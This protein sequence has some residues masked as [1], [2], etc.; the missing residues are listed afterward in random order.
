VTFFGTAE[1]YG[2]FINEEQ[3]GEALVLFKGQV[4]IATKM[5]ARPRPSRGL[6]TRENEPQAGRQDC[7]DDHDD[8]DDQDEPPTSVRA[9][10]PARRSMSSNRVSIAATTESMGISNART[11]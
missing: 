10:K 11:R 5:S 8:H 6:A 7:H 1:V 9:T 2:P 4:V 3:V